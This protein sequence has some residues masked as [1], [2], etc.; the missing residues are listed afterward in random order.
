MKKKLIIFMP[1][2]RWGGVEKSL[3]LI[4]NYLS[5]SL[6]NIY[7]ITASKNLRSKLDKKIKII[8]PSIMNY[9]Q[10]KFFS[11]LFCLLTLI[12]LF[13]KEKN[14]LVFSFQANIYCAIICILFK[15]KII[16]RS[17][18]SPY[19][20]G[21]SFFK[22]K[23]YKLIMKK[24]DKIILNSLEFKKQFKKL[25][26]LNSICIYNPLDVKNIKLKSKEN[27]KLPFF[28]SKK[29][30]IKIISVGRLTDQKDHLTILKAAKLLS[31][32]I[33]FKLLIVGSG[34]LKNILINFIKINQLNKKVK[35]I[36][37]KTNIYKYIK[38]SDL[39]I[40]SSKYEGL[41]N[42]LL[43]SICLNKP[44]ISSDCPT[45]PKEILLGGKGGELFKVQDYKMLSNKIYEFNKDPMKFT[46][47]KE[48]ALK[49]LIRFNYDKNMKEYQ[50]HIFSYL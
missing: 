27:L 11:Y 48:V 35:I 17:N 6:D 15:I 42:I 20:W 44:I 19:G 13:T 25:F 36:S 37:F 23:I 31:K 9:P 29:K 7:L 40:L 22:K 34:E 10:N 12:K 49:N 8:N 30:S 4:A 47:K 33:N 21:H 16:I 2:I 18:T 45:G 1:I 41:P 5:K 26:G 24:V 14:Y 32:K 38:K 50:K 39:V 3:F 28:E 46:N 43:E